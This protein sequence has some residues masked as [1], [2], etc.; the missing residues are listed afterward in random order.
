MKIY[1]ENKTRL[2]YLLATFN[3]AVLAFL[4]SELSLYTNNSD[5]EQIRILNARERYERAGKRLD[6]LY[7]KVASGALASVKLEG[8]NLNV[9]ILVMEVSTNS[10]TQKPW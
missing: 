9:N 1:S 8:T 10:S 4:L 5:T 2:I 6:R 3:C 7:E